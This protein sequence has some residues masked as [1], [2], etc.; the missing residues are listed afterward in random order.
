[1]YVCMLWIFGALTAV[2]TCTECS[3]ITESLS[4]SQ[5]LIKKYDYTFVKRI[6]RNY[7]NT[8]KFL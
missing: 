4:L 6:K 8:L 2:Y 1:M 5:N 7:E 3:K